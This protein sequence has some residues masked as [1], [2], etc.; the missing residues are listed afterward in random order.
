[1]KRKQLT[2]L[3]AL[4]MMGLLFIPIFSQAEEAYQVSADDSLSIIVF[5]EKDLSFDNIKVG[6][7]GKLS[8]PLIGEV[9]VAGLTTNQIQQKI[10]ALLLDGYFKH[11]R[12]TVSIK[13]YRSIFIYGEVRRPGAYPYQKGLTVEKAVV[14]AGGLTARASENKITLV[15]EKQDDEIVKASMKNALLP[16]DIITIEESFF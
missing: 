1:M 10:E 11:P 7:D 2:R 14:L 4:F 6:T 16:G 5:G 3:F 8:F 9:Q 15:H 12:V 13:E